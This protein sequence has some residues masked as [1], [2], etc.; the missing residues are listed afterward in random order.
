[1]TRPRVLLHVEGAAVTALVLL[2]YWRLNGNWLLFVVLLVQLALI[3]VAHIAADRAMGF[4]L[5]YPTQFKDTHLLTSN[6]NQR[7]GSVSDRARWSRLGRVSSA[8]RSAFMP[9]AAIAPC[10]AA[11]TPCETANVVPPHLFR[12]DSSHTAPRSGHRLYSDRRYGGNGGPGGG[13]AIFSR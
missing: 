11:P 1:M 10:A 5:K 4:G 9:A 2:L 7:L 12:C 3:W 13:M 8:T 6:G